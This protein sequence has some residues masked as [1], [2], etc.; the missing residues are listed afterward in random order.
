VVKVPDWKNAVQA[1]KGKKISVSKIAEGEFRIDLKAGENILLKSSDNQIK[2][3]VL[4][5]VSLKEEKNLYGVKKGQNLKNDQ[6]WPLP[7][8]DFRN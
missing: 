6:S 5:V 7:E 4:P 8:Y 1:G 2:A 3:E